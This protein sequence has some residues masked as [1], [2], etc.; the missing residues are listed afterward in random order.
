ACAQGAISLGGNVAEVNNELCILCR[1][2]A[3][4]CPRFAIR[5]V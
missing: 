5:V 3:D 4:A 1:Y 2:C